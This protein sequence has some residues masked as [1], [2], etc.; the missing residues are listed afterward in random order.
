MLNNKL[1]AL[2]GTKPNQSHKSYVWSAYSYKEQGEYPFKYSFPGVGAA[3]AS[4][5]KIKKGDVSKPLTPHLF[6]LLHE[7]GL[8]DEPDPSK[9]RLDVMRVL[10]VGF[11]AMNIESN[12]TIQYPV[13]EGEYL[14]ITLEANF[15]ILLPEA[16]D[17]TESIQPIFKWQPEPNSYE[18]IVARYIR[19]DLGET[20]VDITHFKED[21]SSTSTKFGFDQF[22][23]NDPRLFFNMVVGSNKV[24]VTINSKYS[25]FLP[26]ST[27]V[28][29]DGHLTIL[30]PEVGEQGANNA[31]VYR[32]S[33][34]RW[35]QD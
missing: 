29:G 20:S 24:T 12:P 2:V 27:S 33:L 28:K 8:I 6:F 5:D 34:N 16:A 11:P 35:K 4:E 1:F 32:V 22:S 14:S 10:G 3:L 7:P 9:T 21:G 19:N 13:K 30:Y 17:K 25:G 18:S 31:E 15:M 23:L 26:Y